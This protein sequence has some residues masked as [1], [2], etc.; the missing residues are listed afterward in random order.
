MTDMALSGSYASDDGSTSYQWAMPEY[1]PIDKVQ[2]AIGLHIGS[3]KVVVSGWVGYF[4]SVKRAYC[5]CGSHCWV[6]YEG[7][8]A[9]SETTD[10]GAHL[11]WISTR[12]RDREDH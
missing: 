8:W 4:S 1:S 10:P 2:C 6:W 9:S 3:R 12:V 5:A 11:R 7:G